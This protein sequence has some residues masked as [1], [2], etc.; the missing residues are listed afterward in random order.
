MNYNEALEYIHSVEWR[1]S[2]PG[3]SRT[4]E[5]LERLGNPEKDMKFIHVAGT[6]GKGSTCAMLDSVLRA[7]GYRVGLYTSPYIVRFN[8]RM[9]IG[10]EPISDSELAGLTGFIKPFAEAMEDKPTEFELITAL[11]FLYFKRNGCD[12]VVLEVGMG[13]SFD[14]TNVI[15]SPLV[16]VITGIALDH[17]SVLGNTVSE[18]ALQKAGI[19]KRSRPVV[20]GGRDDEACAV[21]EAVASEKGACFT[22][23]GLSGLAVRSMSVHGTVFDYGGFSDLRLSLAGEYQTDN[24]ATVIETVCALN[25]NG[26]NVSE[27]ALR[28]GFASARWRARFELLSDSPAVVFDGSHNVQGITAAA[29]SIKRYFGG[30]KVNILMGVLADKDYRDM[31]ALLAPLAKRVFTVTPNSPRALSSDK[32]AKVFSEAGIPAVS[33]SS[34]E[35]GVGA[36]YRNSKDENIPLIMLGS[37]YA[38][39]EVY[40]AFKTVKTRL[41]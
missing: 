40:S 41:I 32:L 14:S 13:G 7:E 2:R 1:G 8:E 4:R 17:T 38:Y 27:N 23:T 16:S 5:L 30:E 35:E 18:I 26:F 39:N 34:V 36:A 10:G 6:N 12:V 31:A 15:E 20:Y 21:I 19:I 37:L 11:A 3:L 25:R 9:Q 24:A 29:N 33:Y 22:R 28:S